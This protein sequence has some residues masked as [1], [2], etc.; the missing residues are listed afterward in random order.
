[1][2]GTSKSEKIQNNVKWIEEPIDQELLAEVQEI[3]AP[4]HNETWQ[5]T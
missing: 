3:L 2:V 5:N 4:I 1:L